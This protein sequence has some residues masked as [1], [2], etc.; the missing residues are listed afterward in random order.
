MAAT[1][2]S[3]LRW[4]SIT[5]CRRPPGGA[6]QAAQHRRQVGGG[7]GAGPVEDV[8]QGEVREVHVLGAQPHVVRSHK[9]LQSQ[10]GGHH[11]G[12]AQH[13]TLWAVGG[14]PGG[15][16]QHA[17]GGG[18]ASSKPWAGCSLAVKAARE[19]WRDDAARDSCQLI[20]E[21]WVLSG[22]PQHPLLHCPAPAQPPRLTHLGVA[23][24]ATGVCMGGGSVWRAAEP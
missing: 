17:G 15:G 11:V 23:G 4:P 6:G 16:Q 20:S 3:T 5:P 19:W 18:W 10:D 8:G 22:W 21:G 9:L 12:V 1:A 2:A 7:G 13:H 24:G 14:G